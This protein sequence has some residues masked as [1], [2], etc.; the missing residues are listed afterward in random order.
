MTQE[1]ATQLLHCETSQQIWEDAQSLAGAH[2]RSRITFLKTEFHRTR[3]G[4]LKMEEYL[5]KMKEIADD[6]ALA[7]S[8]V[9]TM[10]LVTQTLAGLDNEYNPIVVQLSDKEHLTWVEMQA[11]LLTYEN[12]LEQINNQSNL[13]LNPSSNISTILYNRRGKSNAFGGGRGGQINRGARGGRG[14]GR[15]TK[16]RIVCQ[17]CCKPGHAASHCYHR[18]NKNYIGQNSDEQKSEKDKEQNY[19]FNAYVASPSTV[20]DL[21]WYFDS[22]ASNHVTYDQN[23]VQEVNENDGKSFLTVGN[24]A[25]LKIIACGDSSL[26]TQQKSLNLKDILYVPKITKNLLSISKLTFDNDIYVEFHDVACFVKDKLTG[27]ILLEGKIKDGLYQLPGGSTSTNKRPHVFFSI[28]ETWHRKLGHPNSKVLNEVMKLCNIEASP[29]ENFEFCEACQFGKAHN[30]P[31]QNS[32]SC[33]KEPL[34]L[35]HSDVWGPAPISSVSG[36]KYY[37]LFLDD[38]SRFT[39]IYPLKQKS[40]VFQAFI[41]FRNLVEN[42]FNKRIKTLQCDGG[43]EFKSLSKVLIKTGIQLRES[44]PYT[45]AQNGRAERKHRHVVESGLTLLAQA[46]MPLHYWWEAFSTAVFLINRLPTQVIKNKSPYQ[47]LFDKNP[48][49][50]AMKTFG[51]AC[52]PCLKPYNQHK[53]QFHTTKCVFLGYSGS[54]KGYKC[55]NSTGRIFISRHVVFNEHHFPFH[56]GFLNTRKPAEIITDPTSLL[57]PISPTGSNVA[58]EEQRLHTNNNSSSNTKSKHQVEQAENQNTIDATISQNTFANSRIENNIESINQHQMTTRSKM[59]IIKPKKPYVG[60][61]E[62]TLEEQ[63]PETTYEAL[64]NPEWKKAMIA[65][66]KALMM[67]KT[68]TLVPYQGQKN[69]IDCKWVFKT[70]Y[71]A[72]GTI[73]RRKARLVA[74]GFQQTLGLDYDETFSPVIKA[75]TVR[76]ILSI[77]VHFNWEIRQMDIN[78]AFLNGELKETVFMRQPEGFL[79]K[80]RPQ[81]ICKLTKAIYGLKQAPRSWY[82]RLRNALLKWGFKNTRSDSSLFVLMSKA[83]ITFL[84]IYV[85]DIIITG[86]SSSFLSSFIKQLNIMFALKDLGSLHYFLGVEACRDASGLYLKQ[87]KYVLDLLKKFNLEHVSSCPTPM[88]TG[89]SLSEEAELMKNPTL[90]RR[91]IGVLQYLT[92]TRPDIAYSV[93]RLSQYMQAPTTIHWQSVK[94]VFRYLKGTMNHCLHIKPSV[95]LDIT[96]FSDADWATNIE[97]R[98]SVAGYC[99]FLGESLI[100]WS[101]KKQRVVSRSSTES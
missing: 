44:C 32:V 99:V 8:S 81:H 54:H 21:D 34:D 13:T 40:D 35:V 96:G 4:G 47:Q 60:A 87:T 43:G 51:C 22:G 65:E 98:K 7:G 71:K 37:V 84:L 11:Q 50:T 38:W 58:N 15:A 82:D 18:F 16:D 91:A 76:I 74:K 49:Y 45:S 62:K 90:Y 9:S 42:Q 73:E 83:H 24:G 20:E 5:T 46:K 97:D 17:V 2:T 79:D 64:E 77:A 23:K 14:R 88:V 86:S 94:R 10:D 3:K 55:L 31:F 29:C 6:L 53:L 69:I 85:D 75:I 89:R 30:L 19:N 61:V 57:F 48:D 59:G 63:E 33:A 67:N 39:W 12:R 28:K 41:Q 72:D 36:F 66:F 27:R 101:S 1:V 70:K 95:D 25:N 68:W 80:S 100:T 56:D 52:Y 78:N 26:D 93:N 92:N